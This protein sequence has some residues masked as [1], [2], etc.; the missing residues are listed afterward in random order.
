MPAPSDLY[1]TVFGLDALFALQEDLPADRTATYLTARR[2][3]RTSHFVHAAC[4]ARGW[5]ALRRLP[6]A[7]IVEAWSLAS[8]RAAR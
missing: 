8:K 1:Y 4:L 5:A 2:P 7:S 3:P 6:D